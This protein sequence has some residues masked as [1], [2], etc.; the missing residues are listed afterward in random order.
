MRENTSDIHER[1]VSH[2]DF[3][4]SMA[5]GED[6]C[7]IPHGATEFSAAQGMMH[8]ESD[9]KGGRF[10][11]MQDDLNIIRKFCAVG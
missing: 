7:T 4:A 11:T 2:T 6:R 1:R 10:F 3:F 8:V 5:G 9:R